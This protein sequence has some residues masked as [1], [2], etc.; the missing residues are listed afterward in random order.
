MNEGKYIIHAT[1]R[2]EGTV[3]RKDVVGAIFGQT[4]G[5]LGEGLQLRDLQRKARIGHVDVSLNNNKGRSQGRI[6]LPSSLDQVSTAVIGAALETIDR[7][8]NSKATMRVTQIE[9]IQSAKR[10]HIIDRAKELLL[11]IVNSGTDESRNILDEV[12]AVLT[13]DTEV[14]FAEMT[15]GPNV[16]ESDSVIIVEGR[17]DVRNLLKYG[18]KTAIAT[19]GSGIKPELVELAASKKVVTAFMDG[20]RGGR[21]LLLE[22][23]G[24]L[25][26]SLTHVALAPR[27]R[28]VE[29]LEG[30][31]ITKCLSQKETASR[32]V[33]RI[34]TEEAKSDDAS[35][36]KGKAS[37]EAPDEVKKWS[38]F[39]DGLKRNQAVIVLDDGSGSDPISPKNLEAAL[40]SSDGAQGIVF[41]GKVT[42]R[43]FE[44]AAGA[45]IANVVG[46][47][48][49]P[50]SLKLGVQ[51]YSA[52]DLN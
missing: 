52:S 14:E 27:S 21:L 18:F 44:L 23:E 11:A 16:Q 34:K 3:A 22:I 50:E 49:G 13:L 48:V 9:N 45:G 36:G 7:V 19:M 2:A 41:S 15:A 4:E 51:A 25:G 10:D 32:A 12:K 5:L 35:V 8:G 17:N 42:N 46:K 37:L 47:T 39:L 1:I 6:A 30:K 29:H 24:K 20:D 28:E 43:I 26:K 38:P 31:V 40:N 33:A